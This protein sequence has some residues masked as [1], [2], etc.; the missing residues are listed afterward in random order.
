MKKAL[1]S[2]FLSFALLVACGGGNKNTP[3]DQGPANPDTN[4]DEPLPDG[5][6]PVNPYLADS[7]WPIWHRNLYAQASSP[8]DAPTAADAAAGLITK[9]FVPL[10]TNGA[11]ELGGPSPW[12]QISTRY[13]DGSRIVWQSNQTQ[14]WKLIENGATFE[15]AGNYVLDAQG[16]ILNPHWAIMILADGHVLVSDA[17]KRLLYELADNPVDPRSAITLVRTYEIDQSRTPGKLI[18]YI[19]SYDG[20]IIYLTDKSKIGAIR[21]SDWNLVATGTLPDTS[22][23]NNFPMDETG[24]IYIV[25]PT[26]MI[27]VQWDGVSFTTSWTVPYDSRGETLNGRYGSGTTPTLMGFGPDQDHLVVIVDALSASNLVAFWRD[28]IPGDWDGVSGYTN[29]KRIAAVQPL[30]GIDPSI[31]NW[32]V[33]NSPV[34]RGYDIA[35]AQYNGL[36]PTWTCANVPG[37]EKYTWSPAARSFTRAFN[38]STVS[39]NSVLTYSAKTNLV[40]GVGLNGECTWTFY[41]LDWNTGGTAFSCPLGD[42]EDWGDGGVQQSL[43]D[44]CTFTYG[45]NTGTVRIG[46]TDPTRQAECRATYDELYGLEK[47]GF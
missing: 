17:S 31:S 35:I 34:V 27:K 33:E 14:V 18:K 9:A 42:S 16:R 45:S 46:V 6:P 1:I 30:A 15:I 12:S 38:N 13:P 47:R 21:L 41:A 25:T 23:H 44:D 40:Y 29:Y 39:I 26:Q 4:S 7:P 8:L 19:V 3:N 20:H 28:E 43:S 36:R 11:T 22:F 37:V 32:A 2:I 24:G 5:D 10:P